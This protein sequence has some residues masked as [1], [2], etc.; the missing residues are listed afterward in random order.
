M[1]ILKKRLISEALRDSPTKFF[2]VLQN[3]ISDLKARISNI[4]WRRETTPVIA[5]R[6][7]FVSRSI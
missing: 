2:F 3:E 6:I 7:G 4:I 1:T 5:N